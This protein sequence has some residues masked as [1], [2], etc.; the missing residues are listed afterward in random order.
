LKPKSQKT[1]EKIEQML[2]DLK[3]NQASPSKTVAPISQQFSNSDSTSSHN[4]TD[5]DI[6][7]LEIFFGKVDLEPRLQRIYNK[8]KTVNFSKNWYSKPTPLDLQFEE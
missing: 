2:S 3:I 4:S 6:K 1:I 5:N 7:I 8:S